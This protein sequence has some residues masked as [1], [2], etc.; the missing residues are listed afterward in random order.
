MENNL[1]QESIDDIDLT[2]EK[3]DKKADDKDEPGYILYS[4][5]L[6]TSKEIL[7]SPV[8]AESFKKIEKVLGTEETKS[9]LTVLSLAMTHSSYNTIQLY[10][11]LLTENVNKMIG[12]INEE[13]GTLRGTINGHQGAMEVFKKRLD[14]LEGK[15]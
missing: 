15:N 2:K 1:M 6:N 9:L 11:M 3:M 14:K 10:D 12:D 7:S 8:F 4:A 13:L 5:I